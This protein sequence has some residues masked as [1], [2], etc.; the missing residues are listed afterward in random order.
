MLICNSICC[1]FFIFYIFFFFK[2]KTAY[3]MRIS[4]WSSDVC[5][6]DLD[7]VRP[8][9]PVGRTKCSAQ[10][11]CRVPQGCVCRYCAIGFMTRSVFDDPCWI[12]ASLGGPCRCPSVAALPREV[13][14]AARRRGDTTNAGNTDRKGPRLDSSD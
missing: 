7:T 10:V 14:G 4:D 12:A 9:F 3:E 8:S 5:S 1:L 11:P 2:Q 6:S 13:A